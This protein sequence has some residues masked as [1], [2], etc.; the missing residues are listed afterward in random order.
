[1]I[2]ARNL[3]FRY[4]GEFVLKNINLEVKEGSFT[5]IIGHNG[6]GKS[7]LA[8][9]LNALLLPT[10][11]I[12]L[13]DG[14]DTRKDEA[15]AR[16]KVGFVFQNF[17]D[18][19]VYSTVAEDVSFGPENLEMGAVQIAKTVNRTLTKL[20]ITS[21]AE[22]N[23]NALSYGQKQMVAL[24]GVLAMNP[25]YIV[26]DEPATM[27][28]IKNRRNIMNII[29]ELNKKHGVAVILVTNSFDD[30]NYADTVIGLKD[31]EILFNNKKSLF[32]EAI[33]KKLFAE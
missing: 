7:T 29:N 5:A 32:T 12:V 28:D 20:G 23:V 14:I 18:Q 6:S 2:E 15:S 13:V 11:G 4:E 16:K 21:L 31:G 25:K 10:K 30:L 24:A 22:R 17:E 1:M 33:C 8:K 27:L 26:F 9:H 3:Y 19:L